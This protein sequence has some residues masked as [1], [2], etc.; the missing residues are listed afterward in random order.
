MYEWA[1]RHSLIDSICEQILRGKSVRNEKGIRYWK[2]ARVPYR[3]TNVAIF[4]A[5][6]IPGNQN[7]KFTNLHRCFAKAGSNQDGFERNK[8]RQIQ[9]NFR[10]M[11]Q[12]W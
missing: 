4:G 1:L 2:D 11:S 9:I 7:F 6:L 3:L 8:Y 12:E 10:K 5:Y